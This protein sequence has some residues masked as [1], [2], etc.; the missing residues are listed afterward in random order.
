MDVMIFRD[1]DIGAITDVRKFAYVHA[2]FHDYRVTH[3]IAVITKDIQ[4]NERLVQ[5]IKDYQSGISIQLHCEEHFPHTDNQ[6]SRDS[7][8][9]GKKTIEDVFGISPV[10]WF[11]PW[12][13]STE[14]L[15]EYCK[16]IGLIAKP[17]KISLDQYMRVEGAVKEDVINFHYWHEPEVNDL[18][19]ALEIFK[20]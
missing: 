19:R 15:A 8:L 4:K 10:Y 5:Y 9:N 6:R 17:I 13:K 20:K 2:I 1:D 18:Y 14:G 11:P 16:E 7:I 3:T 12:N